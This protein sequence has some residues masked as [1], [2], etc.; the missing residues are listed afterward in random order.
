MRFYKLGRRPAVHTRRMVRS[1]AAFYSSV[2][3]LGKPPATSDDYIT[4]VTKQ[5]TDGWGMFLNDKLGD[6]VCADTAHQVMLHTANAGAIVVP[7]DDEVLSYYEVVG[8]YNPSDPSTD[9][10]C[11]ET[12]ACQYNQT[13]GMCGQKS[14]GTTAVDPSNLD[15]VR[16][17]VQ[18]FGACRLGIIVDQQMEEAFNNGEP[19]S[20]PPDV[21]APDAGGHDVPIVRYDAD[22]AYVVTWGG[23]QPI[24]WR[25]MA[26]RSFLEEAHAEV[27]PD[28]IAAGG[29]APN[30]F[31][32]SQLLSDLSSIGE[33]A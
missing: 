22:Y 10:G 21:N 28:F 8:G 4:A 24:E 15:H 29:T 1:M 32:L 26:Q 33:A 25:L 17:A 13:T 12:E 18:L 2:A 16:W 9:R 7:T 5:S 6:C 11:V 14:A 20:I 30:G 3:A 31:D 19:W 23:L 27:Y